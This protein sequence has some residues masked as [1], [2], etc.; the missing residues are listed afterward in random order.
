MNRADLP[1]L[2]K[3]PNGRGDLVRQLVIWFGFV[4]AY[5]VARGLA[6]RDATEAFHNGRRV[7]RLEDALGTL[8]EPDVQHWALGVGHLL[9]GAMSLTYW[10]SQFVVV[11]F[12]LLWIYLDRGNWYLRVRNTIIVANTIG[13]IIYVALPTA[14]PRLFPA[15]GFVNTA[16]DSS[17]GVPTRLVELLANQYA[18]MPSLHAA[19]ALIIGVALA[20]LVRPAWLKAA[21]ALWPAWV[22]FSLVATANHSWAD[23]VAGVSV[24]AIGAAASLSLPWTT[25]ALGLS[26]V[27][28]RAVRVP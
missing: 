24:A 8:F 18:A 9:P 17:L 12:A 16:A 6:D 1:G 7:L 19:D 13:L 5:Q 15:W 2:P 20:L 25:R 14:P 27:D 22:A 28:A 10:L 26:H 23:I 21:F 11:G 4:F 3:L